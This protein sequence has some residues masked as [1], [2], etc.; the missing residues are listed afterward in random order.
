MAI[1]CGMGACFIL[2]LIEALVLAPI[3][4]TKLKIQFQQIIAMGILILCFGPILKW[5]IN[6]H[7]YQVVFFNS[8]VGGLK[9]AQEEGF[10]GAKFTEA[11]DYWGASYRKGLEWLNAHAEPDSYF[12][13]GVAE[14]IINY[15]PSSWIRSDLNFR[16]MEEL[17]NLIQTLPRKRSMYL[18]YVTRPGHYP[19][20]GDTPEQKL[21]H[22]LFNLLDENVE[23]VHEIKVEGATIQK[24]IKIPRQELRGISIE[25]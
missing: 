9:G 24:I 22:Q 1:F 15:T 5:H 11:T 23:P 18:M 2:S 21:L 17:I 16:E 13:V 3:K 4:E 10:M 12:F 20:E 25:Q 19:K 6:N 7:P 14:H 8:V